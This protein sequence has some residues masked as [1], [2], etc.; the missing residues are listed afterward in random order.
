MET[1]TYKIS[2][3]QVTL[4]GTITTR[5]Q[6]EELIELITLLIDQEMIRNP[7]PAPETG[8]T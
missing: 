1:P 2:D 8:G 3:G 7:S 4:S 6:A 5:D